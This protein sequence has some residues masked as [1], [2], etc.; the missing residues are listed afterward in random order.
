MSTHLLARSVGPEYLNMSKAGISEDNYNPVEKDKLKEEQK[1][2]LEKS[3]MPRLDVCI[4]AWNSE[5]ALDTL[6]A[7]CLDDFGIGIGNWTQCQ[8]VFWVSLHHL[9]QFGPLGLRIALH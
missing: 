2:E 5:L 1:A 3:L 9:P 4:E 6:N 8:A 7:S